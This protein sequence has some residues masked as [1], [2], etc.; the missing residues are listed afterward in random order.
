MTKA[1]KRAALNFTRDLWKY[2]RQTVVDDQL[3]ELRPSVMF[4][5]SFEVGSRGSGCMELLHK[6]EAQQKLKQLV[7]TLTT[8]RIEDLLLEV[9][10]G[11]SK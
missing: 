2:V 11:R 6:K 10:Y 3:V 7:D 9:R 1:E 5:G 8:A 4:K